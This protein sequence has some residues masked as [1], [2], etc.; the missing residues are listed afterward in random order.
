[1]N[2]GQSTKNDDRTL[3]L[4]VVAE[5]DKLRAGDEKKTITAEDFYLFFCGR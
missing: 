1:M 2:T 5:Q 3:Y 4:H